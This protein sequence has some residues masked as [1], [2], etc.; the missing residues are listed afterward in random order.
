MATKSRKRRR[1]PQTKW[2]YSKKM[3]T[4]ITVI[5][6]ILRFAVMATSI[7]EPS[8][9]DAM[10]KLVAGADSVMMVN[11]GF[12]TGNSTAEKAILAWMKRGGYDY[13]DDDDSDKDEADDA[14]GSAAV[15]ID[16]DPEE[17]ENG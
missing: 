4:A 16:D 15:L 8:V 9:A 5:W 3:A 14:S 11:L 13:E 2:Q 10:V 7:I 6:C 1:Q 12:Y 17:G